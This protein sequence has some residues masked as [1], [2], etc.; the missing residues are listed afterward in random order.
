M[1]LDAISSRGERENAQLA[2][3]RLHSVN[4]RKSQYYLSS[5][6]VIAWKATADA[7]PRM[8]TYL[9]T[10]ESIKMRNGARDDEQ[11]D[12]STRIPTARGPRPKTPGSPS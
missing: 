6:E 12:F 4:Y 11:A 2:K 7:A 9:N 3:E 8:Y 1:V 10:E 5:L